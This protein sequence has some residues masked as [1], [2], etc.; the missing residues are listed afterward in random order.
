MVETSYSGGF[1]FSSA[2]GR[3]ADALAET[4]KTYRPDDEQKARVAA[5]GPRPC[6]VALD[7]LSGRKPF[8]DVANRGVTAPS[9]DAGHFG[10]APQTKRQEG[11]YFVSRPL[12]P[13]QA[14]TTGQAP[15]APRPNTT[16][17]TSLP[18][19]AEPVEDDYFG[20]VNLDE[21]VSEHYKKKQQGDSAAANTGGGRSEFSTPRPIVGGGGRG[22]QREIVGFP[23]QGGSRADPAPPGRHLSVTNCV[24]EKDL[25]IEKLERLVDLYGANPNDPN[26]P[27]LKS[28]CRRLRARVSARAAPAG[29]PQHG[30]PFQPQTSYAYEPPS[31][32]QPSEVRAIFDLTEGDH[33]QIYKPRGNAGKTFPNPEA[34][35]RGQENV[36][37]NYEFDAPHYHDFNR[38]S[39]GDGGQQGRPGPSSYQ[40]SAG[41]NPPPPFF[42]QGQGS[43]PSFHQ[44]PPRSDFQP[45]YPDDPNPGQG[46]GG[47][48]RPEIPKVSGYISTALIDASNDTKWK[49]N[50]F[51]W[52]ADLMRHNEGYF[53]YSSFRKSQQE[54]M[55]ATLSKQDVFALMPTG[56]GK[57]LCYQLPALCEEGLTVVICPLVALIQDQIAQLKIANIDC[58]ALGSTTD[59][60]E[61]RR[62]LSSLRMNPPEIKLLYVTPEKV[63]E[64]PPLSPSP[65]LSPPP[66]PHTHVQ[67]RVAPEGQRDVVI[68]GVTQIGQWVV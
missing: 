19:P 48:S 54:I 49:R 44:G 26:I 9:I 40:G 52:S 50:N 63:R 21:L 11:G 53:G 68:A 37:P 10:S 65:S 42:D 28:D 33:R 8:S 35:P 32:R 67:L 36:D 60:F 18:A 46:F 47:M 22:V 6:H 27:G 31:R 5:A 3:L 12:A 34:W 25:Y 55:N 59:D 45:P 24:D 30:A 16:T 38:S 66:P 39:T 23:A 41:P 64:P 56:G 14:P 17:T 1:T 43:G 4:A 13:P 29:A 2:R 51:P 58:G 15:S 61:R 7:I 57:S 62:I 20:I